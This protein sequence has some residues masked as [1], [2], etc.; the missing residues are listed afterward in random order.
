MSASQIDPERIRLLRDTASELVSLRL[1]DVNL[2]LYEAG[3]FEISTDEWYGEDHHFEP[4]DRD[5]ARL[6]MVRIRDSGTSTLQSMGTAI[7]Q[8]FTGSDSVERAGGTEPEALELF[9]SHL[10][11][12]RALVHGVGEV[13]ERFGIRLF[14]AHDHIEPDAEWQTEIEAA[15]TRAAGGVVF[16]HPGYNESPWCDQEAGW[17]LGRGVPIRTLMYQRKAPY[18]PLGKRQALEITAEMTATDV[19]RALLSWAKEQPALEGRFVTSITRALGTAWNF[20]AAAQMWSHLA[21]VTS[22]SATQVANVASA[23]RDNNQLTGEYRVVGP[24]YGRWL[25][26]LIITQLLVQPGYDENADLVKEAAADHPALLALL[27]PLPGTA[28]QASPDIWASPT[29]DGTTPF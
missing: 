20:D 28:N 29:Y 7:R 16:M 19:G 4:N 21:D 18:G 17:L 25:P 1:D 12:H 22:M 9:A 26:E 14:V 2:L 13:L 6:V 15:L 3:L 27:P 11:K 10:T 5:R 8:V 24:E 23:L